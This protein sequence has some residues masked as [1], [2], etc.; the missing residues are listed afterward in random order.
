MCD[1][2]IFLQ[3]CETKSG[4]ESLGSRLGIWKILYSCIVSCLVVIPPS[5]SGECDLS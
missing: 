1:F 2:V 3:S 4:T 5:P